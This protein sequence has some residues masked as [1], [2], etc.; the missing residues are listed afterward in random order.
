[1]L[2]HPGSIQAGQIQIQQQEI[3]P[4]LPK[5]G[6]RRQAIAHTINIRPKLAEPLGQQLTLHRLVFNQQHL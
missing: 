6:H 4:V 3:H 1:M 2:K 5:G